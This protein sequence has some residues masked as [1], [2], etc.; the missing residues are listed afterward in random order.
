MSHACS[1]QK[2]IKETQQARSSA[3]LDQSLHSRGTV[4]VLVVVVLVV[5]V[6]VV[7]VVVAQPKIV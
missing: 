3:L 1:Q 6:V 7:L 5:V 2:R 4:V